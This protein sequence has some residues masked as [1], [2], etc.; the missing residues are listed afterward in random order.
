MARNRTNHS[1]FFDY[2]KEAITPIS[3]PSGRITTLPGGRHDAP[4]VT[5]LSPYE[6]YQLNFQMAKEM[7][8]A[9][10]RGAGEMLDKSNFEATA[11]MY[12]EKAKSED[13]GMTT[14]Y[15]V[16]AEQLRTQDE[17]IAQAVM[18]WNGN[19]ELVAEYGRTNYNQFR[20]DEKNMFA[21]LRGQYKTEKEYDDDMSY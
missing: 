17:S 19:K 5:E 6:R 14:D 7:G 8:W 20:H 10:K 11:S 2:Q 12:E 16:F 15:A 1:T 18:L 3:T 13:L 9:F 4:I 21:L